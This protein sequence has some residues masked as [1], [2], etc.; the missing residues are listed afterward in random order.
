MNT[1]EHH[2]HGETAVHIILEEDACSVRTWPVP[3]LRK[4]LKRTQIPAQSWWGHITAR[5]S[6]S[7]LKLSLGIGAALK[8]LITLATTRGCVGGSL[9]W[10]AMIK[11][12][13]CFVCSETTNHAP[14]HPLGLLCGFPWSHD[15]TLVSTHPKGGRGPARAS[16]FSDIS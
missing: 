15:L 7:Q 12:F 6:T 13:L 5:F 2:F 3:C 8:Y 4:S 14:Q 10:W 1:I 9:S 16:K 11:I